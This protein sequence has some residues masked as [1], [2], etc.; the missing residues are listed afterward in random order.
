MLGMLGCTIKLL[1][2]TILHNISVKYK[3]I[4][5]CRMHYTSPNVEM[6]IYLTNEGNAQIIEEA[7]FYFICLVKTSSIK[8][9]DD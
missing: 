4:I 6:Q 8:N 9:V 2:K 7:T 1:I 5:R 3:L